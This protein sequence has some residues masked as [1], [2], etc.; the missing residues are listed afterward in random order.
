M[1]RLVDYLRKLLRKMVPPRA[2]SSAMGT[3]VV[4]AGLVGVVTGMLVLT[5]MWATGFVERRLFSPTDGLLTALARRWSLLTLV[6]PPLTVAGVLVLVAWALR[7][8]APEARGTG[9]DRVMSAVGRR[10]GFIRSRVVAFKS[11]ATALCIGVGAPLGLEGPVVHAGGALGSLAGRRFK[12]GVS[13][14]RILVAA[15]AAAGLATK[16]GAPIAGAVF[17]AELIL[18]GAGTAALLPLILASFLAVAARNFVLQGAPE[19]V[20]AAQPNPGA[21]DYV[22]FVLLGIACGLVAVYAIKIVFTTER[23]MG[24]LFRRW[25]SRALAA[26]LAIG[27]LGVLW[28]DILRTGKPVIQRLLEEPAFPLLALALL[29]VM[30]PLLCSVALGTGVS[31]GVFGP[32]LLTGAALGAL[33]ARVASGVLPVELAPSASYVMAAMAGV[34]AGVMRAPL[35][36][37]IITFELAHDYSVLLPLMITC[38]VSTKV[39]ELFEPE[40][41]FTRKLVQAGERLRS[42]MDLSLLDG[43]TV[44]DVMERDYV[45]LPAKATLWEVAESVRSSENRTFPVVGDGGE[46]RGI[47]MLASL[48]AAGVESRDSDRTPTVEELLEPTSVYLEPDNGLYDAWRTMGNYDYDCL[49]VCRAGSHGLQVVGLCE[50]EA[51]LELHDRQAFIALR[52]APPD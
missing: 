45:A 49:P 52:R 21:A 4:L 41:V 12:M 8:W 1:A 42:G 19:Y 31:G 24:R 22:L 36:A 10:G 23:A 50:K 2:E 29:I 39:S 17:S 35:Q 25:W 13:N 47:V 30:K 5:M 44:D 7:R 14:I 33:F 3:T 37:I 27:L 20:I 15:G 40:S 6:G 48:I 51:I 11:I 28:P 9:T 46:L 26:G 18:G 32:S 34:I 38:V 43:I 16:Y